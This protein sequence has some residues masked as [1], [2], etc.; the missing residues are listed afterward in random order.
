MCPILITNGHCV[1]QKWLC[2]L[3]SKG[4]GNDEYYKI[5]YYKVWYYKVC[6]S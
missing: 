3:G 5:W 4:G 2:C 1:L 6:E